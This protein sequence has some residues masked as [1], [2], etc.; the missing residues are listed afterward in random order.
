MM[1]V[2]T[3]LLMSY[4]VVGSI[5]NVNG[6]LDV[7]PW[8]IML[9]LVMGTALIICGGYIINDY[10]DTRIDEVN[11]PH[12]VLIGKA[13]S[14]H[15]AMSL[16][17]VFTAL[18]VLCGFIVAYFSGSLTVALIFLMVPGLLWFYSST[19]KRQFFV[20]NVVVG[21]IA[22][23]VPI[24]VAMVEVAY[25]SKEYGEMLQHMGVIADIYLW[26]GFFSVFAFALIVLAE[27]VKDMRDE[28]GDREMECNTV[29]IVLGIRWA[30]AIVTLFTI[31]LIIGVVCLV[32]R[33]LTFADTLLLKNF[34]LYGVCAPLLFF[35]FVLYRSKTPKT[36]QQARNILKIVM[37]IG[38][39]FS[40]VFYYALQ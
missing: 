17:Q 19:Y 8:W 12:R 2:V 25:L 10:F 20:G 22:A 35:I 9:L 23:F 6:L 11:K 27:M 14:R 34:L 13:I 26:V 40:L 30:K 29:P 18:G 15:S 28:E 33:Q 37:L 39:L 16:H 31:L 7:V 4:A 36:Y 1:V 3:Q 38:V 5:L 21:L 32:A 24:L